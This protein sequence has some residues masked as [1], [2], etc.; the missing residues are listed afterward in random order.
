MY[1]G[2]HEL[3]FASKHGKEG[4]RV[5][6]LPKLAPSALVRRIN[7]HQC[8]RFGSHSGRVL[9]LER[10]ITRLVWSFRNWLETDISDAIHGRS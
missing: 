10:E 1:L 6:N 7:W 8:S 4:D 9:L 2:C 5:L 3:P